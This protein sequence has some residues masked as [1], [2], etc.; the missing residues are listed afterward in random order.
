M[1][2]LR[3]RQKCQDNL[4]LSLF[5]FLFFFF[6][7]CSYFIILEEKKKIEKVREKD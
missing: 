5:S 3:N 2:M 4:T 7:T 1:C 6:A